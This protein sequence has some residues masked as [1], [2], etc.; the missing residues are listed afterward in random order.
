MESPPPITPELLLA[1]A[2]SLRALARGLLAEA[3]ADDVLQETWL[4]ALERPPRQREGLGAWLRS[5]LRN[6]ARL[7][8]RSEARRVER[9][10][11]AARPESVDAGS[12]L[13]ERRAALHQLVSA[14]ESLPEPY[15]DALWMRFF[16]DLPT[17]EIAARLGIAEAT[18]RSRIHRGLALLRERLERDSGGDPGSWM[19][20]LAAAL[21]PP[22]AATGGAA[23]LGEGSSGIGA[24]LMSMNVK[25]VAVGITLIVALAL[26][27]RA[28]TAHEDPAAIEASGSQPKLK[29]AAARPASSPVETPRTPVVTASTASLPPEVVESGTGAV[30]DAPATTTVPVRDSS[31]PEDGAPPATS[32][33]PVLVTSDSPPE[34]VR[35]KITFESVFD[36]GQSRV[37]IDGEDLPADQRNGEEATL[38]Q[39]SE[40]EIVDEL[41]A[42]DHDGAVHFRRTHERLA[43]LRTLGTEGGADPVTRSPLEGVL[44]EFARDPLTR[45]WSVTAPRADPGVVPP[46]LLEGLEADLDLRELMPRK[47]L[48]HGSSYRIPAQDL[49]PLFRPGGDVP[50][51][52]P[53]WDGI[54]VESNCLGF[55]RAPSE[56]FDRPKGGLILVLVGPHEEDPSLQVFELDLDLRAVWKV[57]VKSEPG[58]PKSYTQ[59]S[60]R[61]EWS[62]TGRMV[63]DPVRRRVRSLTLEGET[64]AR[65]RLAI[66][67]GAERHKGFLDLEGTSSL[68]FE[69][70]SK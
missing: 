15:A 4:A 61:V 68:R 8:L 13:V 66:D 59:L 41:L 65:V 70:Q 37:R 36:L 11:I 25:V 34:K 54:S 1:H 16:D 10:R 21:S 67:E 9:D 24:L 55:F 18:V 5:V 35:R 58:E 38:S 12:E 19:A 7:W 46:E 51:D 30:V 45:E 60:P 50:L 14:L 69:D 42:S 62:A 28:S 6:R 31:D 43:V 3:A 26:V 20:A 64:E 53:I 40:A 47:G 2:P 63:W 56:A 33:P 27:W 57:R 23:V 17:P 22:Q 39:R 29:T 49:G 44:L 48:S 32:R 52:M